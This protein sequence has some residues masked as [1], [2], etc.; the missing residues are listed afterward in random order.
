MGTVSKSFTFT[1]G[2]TADPSQVNTDL[3]T[4]YNLVNGNIDDTNVKAGTLTNAIAQ[5]GVTPSKSKGLP[6]AQDIFGRSFILSGGLPIID[7]TNLTQIDVPAYVAYVLQA[8]GSLRRITTTATSFQVGTANGTYYL[9]LNP[10]G[11]FNWSGTHSNQANYIPICT[12]VADN[13]IHVST[14]TDNRPTIINYL[15]MNNMFPTSLF[16]AFV[17]TGLTASKDGT[18][19]N[20]LNVTSGTAYPQQTDATIRQKGIPATSFMTSALNSTYYLDLNPNGSYSFGTSHSTVT[21]YM[22]IAQ[23]TTDASGNISGVLDVAQRTLVMLPNLA[24]SALQVGSVQSSK[25]APFFDKLAVSGLDGDLTL[26]TSNTTYDSTNNVYNYTAPRNVMYYHNLTIPA[27]YIFNVKG[28]GINVICVSGTLTLNGKISADG[29]IAG[30]SAGTEYAQGGAGGKGGGIL[31][32]LANTISGNGVISASGAAGGNGI[33][34]S[35]PGSNYADGANGTNGSFLGQSIAAGGGGN[36][37]TSPGTATA[38]TNLAQL[39]DYLV[40]NMISGSTSDLGAAGGGGG[41]TD[42]ISSYYYSSGAGGAGLIGNGGNGATNNS[43][44][45]GNDGTFATGGGGGGGGLAAVY[46]PNLIPAI[47]IQANGGN[48]GNSA[49]KGYGGGGGGAGYALTIAPSS[50]ATLQAI[51]GTAGTSASATT[52]AASNGGA[53]ITRAVAA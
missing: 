4:L 24:S 22:P 8:D 43:V 38:P 19:A 44:S 16:S 7:G 28:S 42:G 35:T 51:G 46:S 5:E 27:G 49:T 47:T 53:G 33:T 48:G 30:G 25:T 10:D 32:V 39:I 17:L 34:G 37:T 45:W 2:T 9:D 29:V 1:N 52:T 21:N 20:K 31:F 26:T 36:H 6:Y 14:I 12:V 40:T 3:D 11:T 18:T 23:V 15:D 50:S 41:T 13:N